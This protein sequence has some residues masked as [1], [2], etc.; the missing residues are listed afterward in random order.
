MSNLSDIEDTLVNVVT[1]ILYPNGIDNPSIVP[2]VN[3]IRIYAGWPVPPAFEA[4]FQLNNSHVTIFPQGAARNT[5]RFR[6][7]WQTIQTNSP[8]IVLTL[9]D[10][11]IT[12]TGT[13]SVPQ[14]V[15][16]I[17][18]GIGYAYLLQESDTLESIAENTAALIPSAFSESNTITIPDAYSI[19]P[20][21]TFYGMASKEIKRQ[22]IIFSV[23]TW[24]NSR[25]NRTLIS[26][27]LESSLG[28]LR[29]FLVPTD[30]Y[31]AMICYAGIK[32]HEEFQKTYSIYR[33]DLMFKIEYATTVSMECPSISDTISNISIVNTLS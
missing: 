15:M 33:R 22:E 24:S 8:T 14:G 21:V 7:D 2:S 3:N 19:I 5:T 11:V 18:N 29:R 28:E 27:A 12:I 1:G 9:S 30:N 4:D 25:N 26:D 16:I 23:I 32:D 17:V 10:N 6:E 20:R 31:Y 13:V